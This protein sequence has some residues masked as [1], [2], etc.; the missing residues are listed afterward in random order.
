MDHT[1]RC[2]KKNVPY[3][4]HLHRRPT[5]SGNRFS[6]TRWKNYRYRIHVFGEVKSSLKASETSF[7]FS[8]RPSLCCLVAPPLRHGKR[9]VFLFASRTYVSMSLCLDV[10]S[11]GGVPNVQ[12]YDSGYIWLVISYFKSAV[13]VCSGLSLD[14]PKI[15]L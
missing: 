3:L 2:R 14:I 7:C 13:L 11:K 12:F 15:D 5:S 9:V 10:L 4:R 8:T 6:R 1:P